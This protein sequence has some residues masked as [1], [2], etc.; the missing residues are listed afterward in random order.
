MKN[1]WILN[2]YAKPSGGRHYKFAENLIKRGY[3]VKI[4]CASTVHNSNQ[5]MITNSRKYLYEIHNDVPFVIIRARSY[6]GNGAERIKNMIDYAAGL[7]SVSKKFD[8]EKPDVIYA[9]SVH[10]LTWLAGYK[11]SKRYGAK[12]IAETRDLWPETFVAMGKM[13]KNSIPAK[14]LYK[15]EKFIYQKAD[16]LIFTFPGGKDYVESIGLDS[17]KVRYINNGVDLEEFNQNK[18]RYVLEDPDLDDDSTFKILYTGSM[19]IA[20]ALNNIVYAAKVLND[21]GYKDIKFLLFGDGYKRKELEDYVKVNDIPNVKFKGKVDKK[22]IPGILSKSD[23]NIFTGKHIYLY[24]YGLSLN[25]MFEYFASGRPTV[26]NVECGYDMLEKYKCGITVKGGS[27][28]ALAEGILK[29]YNMP[30]EEYDTYCNNALKA[31]CD[32][33]FKIL[34]D[35][36]EEV[37]LED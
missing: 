30:K 15:I 22:Y 6:K 34:T 7:M 21:K 18:T 25:K 11:L 8:T 36:L 24:K 4:F 10:P 31:A 12:F 35:K 28:E 1:I 17:S 20:N 14:I 23:L 3:N 2:H 27:A 33:D 5:N 29:F 19:G 9:S 32:F 37:I 26:S 13:S 16:K